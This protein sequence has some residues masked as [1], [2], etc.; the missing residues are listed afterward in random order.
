MFNCNIECAEFDRVYDTAVIGGGCA[1]VMAALAAAREGASVAVAEREYA[2]GGSATLAQ[3]LPRMS[4]ATSSG[5]YNSSLLPELHKMMCADGCA[6]G[7]GWFSPVLLRVYLERMCR[8]YGVHI[9]YGHDIVA[10]PH[11]NG[12]VSGIITKSAEGLKIL[13]AK[14]Y[15]DAT[16]NA[17]AALAA[18]VLCDV[19]NGERNQPM[20]LRF[21]IRGVNIPR[22]KAFTREIGLWADDASPIYETASLWTYKNH[23][24]RDIFERAVDAGDLERRDGNYFQIFN[25][26]CAGG[27]II[28]CN[29]PEAGHLTH[30]TV[31]ADITEMILYSR[32]AAVR[33]HK[34]LKKYINGFE[35]SEINSFSEIPGI[36]ESRRIHGLY[37]LTEDD[38]I[39]RS[40]FGDA[41]AQSAYPIDIHDERALRLDHMQK[42]E[43]YEIPFRVMQPVGADNMLVA[44]RCVSA[45]FAMQASLRVQ[46]TCMALGEA[47]GIAAALGLRDGGAVRQRMMEHG[48]RFDGR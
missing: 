20:T 25:A 44:G 14:T 30:S 27:D 45:S 34:F 46:P 43:Y 15:I 4:V 47:A 21:S 31:D 5:M 12:S 48:A 8:S 37:T 1:G 32:E 35:D 40:K 13:R 41:V 24:L 33:I 7:E 17:D 11:E 22:L 28:W 10:V 16:G 6:C 9:L 38:F 19:G 23:G 39:A 2:L 29:C 3:V 42:G 36:R 26:A 18:G